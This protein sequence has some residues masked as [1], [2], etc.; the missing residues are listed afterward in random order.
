MNIGIIGL[1]SMGKRRLRL[2]QEHFNDILLCGVDTNEARRKEV[3]KE[4]GIP[5]Y[6]SLTEAKNLFE[7]NSVFVCTSPITHEFII[8][9]ALNLDCNIF[10][11]INLLNEYYDEIIE[12]AK[13]KD[14]LLYLSSTFLKRKEIQYIKSKVT[15]NKKNFL[16]I[17]CRTVFTRLASL[18]RLSQ[19]FLFQTKKLMGV[20]K[21]SLLNYL[22]L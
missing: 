2:I 18:G 7:I 16:S 12:V 5:T 3:E 14:R 13:K 20:E 1:G 9:E 10:T 19:F 21:Y 4:F 22:G 11:E 6:N 8:K 17:P 15:H